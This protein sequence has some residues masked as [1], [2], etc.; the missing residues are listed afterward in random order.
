MHFATRC[1]RR[2][3]GDDMTSTATT[4]TTRRSPRH[5]DAR[6]RCARIGGSVQQ[7]L[8]FASLI[9]IFVFFSIA[10]PNF[11]TSTT[12]SASCWPPTVTGL[13]ALGTTFVIITGGIDLSIGTGMT[14]CAVMT[15][16]F[17]TYWGWP[18][19]AGVLGAILFGGLI[20]FVNGFNVVGPR[21]PAVHR[22]A[23]HD[24]RRAGP[25]AGDLRH[26]ADLLQRA[27]GLPAAR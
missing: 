23:R 15:G 20:G 17:L 4:A 27:P 5:A 24:A 9:A 14:L 12:S 25:G 6:G 19:W 26:Q 2:R 8:A 21:H 3:N 10:S 7:L 11:L 22:H 1:E 13:L 18:V 16:V